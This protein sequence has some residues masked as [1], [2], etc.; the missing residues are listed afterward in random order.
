MNILTSPLTKLPLHV[1]KKA[2]RKALLTAMKSDAYK[3]NP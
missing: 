2:K 1:K 3:V